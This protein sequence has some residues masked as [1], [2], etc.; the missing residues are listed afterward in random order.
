[1]NLVKARFLRDGEQY[2]RAYTY[3]ANEVLE[4]GDMV[5]LNERG[6][7][8]VIETNVPESEVECFK[9]KLKTVI[10]KISLEKNE[11]KIDE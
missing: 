3:I 2:G 7:G 4:V 10:G 8:V 11:G 1:M 6:I 5:Q 9:D